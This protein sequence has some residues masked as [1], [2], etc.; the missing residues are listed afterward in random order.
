MAVDDRHLFKG[1]NS[2]PLFTSRATNR[3]AQTLMRLRRSAVQYLLGL[4]NTSGLS[5]LRTG[6]S[7]G[8][9]AGTGWPDRGTAVCH[10]QTGA[11]AFSL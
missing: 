3:H 10:A 6:L 2:R 5:V 9:N 1:L 7:Q 8:G 4:T 11:S